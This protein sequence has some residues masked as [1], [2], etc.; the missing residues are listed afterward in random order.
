MG[1]Q[2]R[3]KSREEDSTAVQDVLGCLSRRGR[4][5]SGDIVCRCAHCRAAISTSL[6]VCTRGQLHPVAEIESSYVSRNGGRAGSA[7]VNRLDLIEVG[8]LSRSLIEA[9][10]QIY[11]DPE[12]LI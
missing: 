8:Y 4:G 9:V 5:Q 2:N 7:V 3:K 12:V 10:Y 6:D 1:V 11:I